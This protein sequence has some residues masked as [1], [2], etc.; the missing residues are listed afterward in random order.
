MTNLLTEEGNLISSGASIIRA[1]S[2]GDADAVRALLAES[3]DVDQRG[4]GGHT[5]LMVAAIFGHVDIARLLLAAGADV[6]LRDSLGLTARDWAERRGSWDVAQL[7]S[8]AS[9]A[10]I[11]PSHEAVATRSASGAIRSQ[12]EETRRP[13]EQEGVTTRSTVDATHSQMEEAPVTSATDPKSTPQPDD[14]RFKKFHKQIMAAQERRKAEQAR[15]ETDLQ[16]SRIET[17]NSNEQVAPSVFREQKMIRAEPERQDKEA[18]PTATQSARIAATIEHLRLQEE[19]SQPPEDEAPTK[20][21]WPAQTALDRGLDSNEPDS[22]LDHVPTETSTRPAM[23][24]SRISESFNPPPSKRCPECNTT[25][26]DPLLVYCAYDAAKLI[27]ADDSMFNSAVAR[28]WSR[29]TLWALVAVIALLGVSLGYLINNYRS[30][31]KA[32]SAPIAAVS[33]AP[34]AIQPEQPEITRN[35]SPLISGELGGM[36]VD[37][38]EPEYPAKARAEGVSGIVKVRVQVNKK[39]KVILAR[40]SAGDWRLRAAAV[41]AA[42]KAT[43]SPEK[44]ALHERVTSGTI[45]YNFV[46]QS[47]SPVATKPQEPAPRNSPSATGT[48]TANESSVEN[49]GGEYPMVGGPLVG[50]E[51]NLPQPGYPEKARSKGTQGTITVVVRV[52]RAGRVISWRTLEGDSQLRAAALKAAKKATFSPNKLPGKG[53]VVGTITYN[54]KP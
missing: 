25:Y 44:L 38:P 6:Q 47:E 53:E 22:T 34:V 7:I 45:T 40:S 10:E 51:S 54:F 18:R 15:R 20:S 8:N 41:K 37:V 50:A 48:S 32:P 1:T 14:L 3:A 35:D 24:R 30:T 52:N 12:V 26:E 23:I 17:K 49:I 42:Q 11:E 5:A 4:R 2:N 19:S 39:G 29:Q 33:N 27:S 21:D 28:D 31:E 36:E 13:S 16:T 9:P 43:F 46:A